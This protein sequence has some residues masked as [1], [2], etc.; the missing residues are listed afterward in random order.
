MRRSGVSGLL[1]IIGTGLRAVLKLA[2][3]LSTKYLVFYAQTHFITGSSS[4]LHGLTLEVVHTK[5]LA[6]AGTHLEIYHA[7]LS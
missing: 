5:L 3:K 7:K 6:L 4:R 1:M 2:A